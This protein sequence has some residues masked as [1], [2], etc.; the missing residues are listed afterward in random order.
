[1]GYDDG[2]A[3]RGTEAADRIDDPV[4]KAR[5]Q[6]AG[7]HPDESGFTV[8]VSLLRTYALVLRDLER[9]LRPLGLTISRFE[10]LLL[11]SFARGGRLPVMRLRDLLLVH[12]SS[13][14][15]LV[16]RLTEAGWVAREA[17]PADR[18]VSIV[19]LTAA[20]RARMEAG[21]RA[22]TEAGFGPIGA[23]DEDARRELSALLAAVRGAEAP[24]IG[25][26]V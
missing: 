23:L 21:V 13:A 5:R 2:V 8:L 6:W 20:G 1:M 10:V 3:T 19:R 7:R 25:E 12:G 18:R 17:D 24:R 11:L 26:P 14:T 15:Y 4:E 22:L 9:R 16:D